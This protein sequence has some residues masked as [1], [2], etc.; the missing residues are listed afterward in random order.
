[1]VFAEWWRGN[2][3]RYSKTIA[4]LF[5]SAAVTACGRSRNKKQ[6]SDESLAAFIA[7]IRAVDNHT[8]ANAVAKK[9]P[10]SDAL[11]LETIFP[12]ELPMRIRPDGVVDL[13]GRR[14]QVPHRRSVTST[15]ERAQW[16][17]AGAGRLQVGWTRSAPK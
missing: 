7:K 10:D 5:A 2:M 6:K 12:F 16:K 9:N 14:L 1:V 15:C 4:F 13:L 8:H 3:R 17:T 11:P